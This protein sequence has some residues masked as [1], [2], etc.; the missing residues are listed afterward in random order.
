MSWTVLFW[1]CFP[2]FILRLDVPTRH[3]LLLTRG[4]A[5]WRATGN[6]ARYEVFGFYY[7]RSHSD[8]GKTGRGGGEYGRR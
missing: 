3:R 1:E 7:P 5:V 2:S 8:V 6:H 4:D